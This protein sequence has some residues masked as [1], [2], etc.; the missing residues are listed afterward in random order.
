MIDLPSRMFVERKIDR[1]R[2]VD[3]NPFNGIKKKKE[4]ITACRKY[5]GDYQLLST[6]IEQAN[7]TWSCTAIIRGWSCH[8]VNYSSKTSTRVL[9]PFD[10]FILIALFSHFEEDAHKK[11]WLWYSTVDFSQEKVNRHIKK[12]LFGLKR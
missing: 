7:N 2:E 6:L 9:N 12:P 4:E 3:L 5:S 8:A 11:N 1:K 10:V